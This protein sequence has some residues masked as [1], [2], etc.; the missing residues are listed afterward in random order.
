MCLVSSCVP[1]TAPDHEGW[2]AFSRQ[3]RQN[4]APGRQHSTLGQLGNR[5]S[6]AGHFFVSQQAQAITADLVALLRRLT[7]M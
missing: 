4:Q 7:E 6:A 3:Y 2:P 5:V 1:D